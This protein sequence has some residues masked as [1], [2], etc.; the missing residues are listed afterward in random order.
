MRSMVEL[1]NQ[2]PS[3]HGRNSGPRYSIERPMPAQ[4]FTAV[5]GLDGRPPAIS[6][7]S[8]DLSTE[9]SNRPN[10]NVPSAEPVRESM[11]PSR[12]TSM[13]NDSVLCPEPAIKLSPDTAKRKRLMTEN[14]EYSHR[15]SPAT[16]V[17][18]SPKRRMTETR[19]SFHSNT[20][21]GSTLNLLNT[22]V[23]IEHNIRYFA[24]TP[25]KT[26]HC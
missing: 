3:D 24:V 18:L 17:A 21:T 8:M 11:P 19:N 7:S 2:S 1:L 6:E 13:R 5:N 15:D 14:V 22:H 9:S 12:Q 16:A 10:N 20:P 25:R 4:G 23:S 26:S